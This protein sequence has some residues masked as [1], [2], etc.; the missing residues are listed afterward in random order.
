MSI[1]KQPLPWHQDVWTHTL[2]VIDSGQSPHAYLISA[3]SGSG[4]RFFANMLA[5]RLICH[6]PQPL[7]A[8]G[9][10]AA[11]KLNIAG[12]NPDL[13]VIRP[14]QKSKLIK[15]E[16]IRELKNFLETSSHSFAKRVIILDTAES[17]N[18]SSANALLKSLEEPPQD[19]VFL[20]LSDRPKAVLATIAS[21][22]RALKLEKPDPRQALAWLQEKAPDDTKSEDIEFALDYAQGRVF[23]ALAMLTEDSRGIHDAIGTDLLNIMQNRELATKMAGRYQKANCLEVLNIMSYWLSALAKFALTGDTQHIKGTA[24]QQA[25]R[26][27]QEGLTPVTPDARDLLKLYTQVSTAQ[28]QLAGV[29]NPN[30]QL[31][32]EDLLIQLQQLF[33]TR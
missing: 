14:E 30:Q 24:L 11:C 18:I 3:L 27:W 25:A 31:M 17:L 2:Q 16:Q 19:V 22:C 12:N 33:K 23:T 9:S 4:K 7:H 13:I 26:L 20:V 15:I 10:C 8:C 5:Q 32:L 28:T 21:R 29:S 1:E 6:R